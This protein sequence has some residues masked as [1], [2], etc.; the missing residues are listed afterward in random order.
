MLLQEHTAKA[1]ERAD[2]RAA[3]A[4]AGNTLTKYIAGKVGPT[5]ETPHTS[6]VWRSIVVRIVRQ[7]PRGGS[8]PGTFVLTTR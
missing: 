2:D 4:D 7:Q 6:C 8:G 1:F 5:K 3:T